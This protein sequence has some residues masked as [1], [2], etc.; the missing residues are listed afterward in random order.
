[1]DAEKF[2][3]VT[4]SSLNNLLLEKEELGL[5]LLRRLKLLIL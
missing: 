3:F 2:K 1:M 5:S 4:A